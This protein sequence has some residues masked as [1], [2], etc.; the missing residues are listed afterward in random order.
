[1]RFIKDILCLPTPVIVLLL[2]TRSAIAE[3][4]VE[5]QSLSPWPKHV[6][7]WPEDPPHR[8]RDLEELE[9]HIKRG[10]R[11]VGVMK[12]SPD[13]GEKFYM[14]YWQ[15]GG[16][17]EPEKEGDSKSSNL[18]VR[19]QEEESRLLANVSVIENFRAPFA[20]HTQDKDAQ[21]LRAR[22]VVGRSAAALAALEKRDFTCP[23]GT[24]SC[25]GIGYPNSCCST[26]ET[27]FEI[28]DTGLGP[29]GCCPRGGSCGGTISV[30]NSPNT[31]CPQNLGG[32]CCI[33]N[34]VCAGVGC[35]LKDRIQHSIN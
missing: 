30:C 21:E 19:E 6:R 15:Y 4:S 31:A 18:R 8:R 3:V 26:D 17:P 16:Q 33:P 29:V 9:E 23:S 11:P 5:D 28:Q 12:M 25:S 13:P 1:M 24:S 2:S 32:G 22:A 27:C 20:L 14:E 10:E 34:Y 35:K 7:Y